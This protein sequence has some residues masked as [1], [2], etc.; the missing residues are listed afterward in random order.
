[1]TL[2][3]L[4]QGTLFW[5]LVHHDPA[6]PCS[7]AAT[8]RFLPCDFTEKKSKMRKEMLQHFSDSLTNWVET[9]MLQNREKG[10]AS[11]LCQL[12]QLRRHA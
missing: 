8:C 3:A 7:A 4:T 1:M 11:D 12:T 2:T 9:E 6:A 5:W 10:Q